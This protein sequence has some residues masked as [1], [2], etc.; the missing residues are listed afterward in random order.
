[1]RHNLLVKKETGQ[2]S[3]QKFFASKDGDTLI[4]Y[5][6]ASYFVKPIFYHPNTGEA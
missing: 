6:I 5:L 2:L 4:P 1:M 3:R